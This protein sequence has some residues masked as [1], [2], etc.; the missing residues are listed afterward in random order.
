MQWLLDQTSIDW[1]ELSRLYEIAPLGHKSP[2]R[3][4]LAFSNSMFT[5]AH[6]VA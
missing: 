6:A 5:G 4:Q 1:T 2:E 3:L